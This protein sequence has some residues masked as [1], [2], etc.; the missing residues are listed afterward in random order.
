M[1]LSRLKGMNLLIPSLLIALDPAAIEKTLL[2]EMKALRVHGAAIVVVEK[3][4]VVM[5]KGLGVVSAEDG[6]AVSA[7]TL[8]RMGSTAKVFTAMTAL[9][10]SEAGKLDLDAAIGGESGFSAVTM[11]QLLTHTAGIADEAPQDGPHDESALGAYA[12]SLGDKY[13]LARPGALFSYA[14]TGYVLAG[15]ALAR[16]TGEPFAKTVERLVF[17]PLGMASSTYRP[18]EA[19]TR[20]LAA[21]HGPDGKVLRP[22]PDHAGAWPP[23]SA[24]TNAEDMA[25][26]LM[27]GLPTEIV[28]PRSRM[29]M[30]GREYGYGVMIE[31]DRVFHTGARAG[32]GSRFELYPKHEVALFVVGNRTGALF[33]KTAE[34]LRRQLGI[35]EQNLIVERAQVG[36]EQARWMAGRYANGA[37]KVELVEGEGGL[38]LQLT[39]RR[40][41]VDQLGEGKFGVRGGAQLEEFQM[42]EG[43]EYLCAEAWCL[44]KVQ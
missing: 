12:K 23:G 20:P 4:R 42:V 28:K 29:W 11:R 6:T 37:L 8:F 25:K 13:R 41:R 38:F 2:E 7:K 35:E 21:P 10:L 32:F 27:A 1:P 34:E 3:G 14:N 9:R 39:G 36:G 31:K 18:F 30:A 40:M 26:F 17:Q 22:F 15:D 5:A 16:A 19:M 24:F 44:R 43:N 33:G